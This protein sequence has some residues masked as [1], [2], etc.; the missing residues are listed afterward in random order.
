MSAPLWNRVYKVGTTK[1]MFELGWQ[2]MTLRKA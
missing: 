2:A 1:G